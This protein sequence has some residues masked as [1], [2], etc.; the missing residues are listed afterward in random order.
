MKLRVKYALKGSWRYVLQIKKW[1]FWKTI[2]TFPTL[3]NVE[4]FVKNLKKVDDFNESLNKSGQK[5]I[6]LSAHLLTK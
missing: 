5:V 3:E 6:K 4:E 1:I 2:A